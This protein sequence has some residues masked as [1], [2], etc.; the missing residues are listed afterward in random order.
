MFTVM[1][2][3]SK[4]YLAKSNVAVPEPF[5]EQF[6]AILFFRA[7]FSKPISH[8]AIS[9]IPEA[10]SDEFGNA[11]CRRQE[12]IKVCVKKGDAN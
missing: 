11:P 1:S 9:V 5:R 8:P 7:Q 12:G 6:A 3:G 10:A 4:R 2:C